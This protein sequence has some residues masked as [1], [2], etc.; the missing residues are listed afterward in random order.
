MDEAL[1]GMR[2]MLIARVL[3]FF[4]Y[5]DSYLDKDVPCA[6]VN[7]FVLKGDARDPDTGMW[8]VKPE[9]EGNKRTLEVIHLDSIARGAHLLP[10]YGSGVLPEDFDYTSALDAFKSYYVNHFA[11]HH[12]YEFLMKE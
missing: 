8:V 6:L 5:H 12:S 1:P 11:D 2:G 4:Q 7:W 3:M 10:V 9:V